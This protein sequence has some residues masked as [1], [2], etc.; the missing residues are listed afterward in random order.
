[1]RTK[2]RADRRSVPPGR[3][4]IVAVSTLLILAGAAVILYGVWKYPYADAQAAK[5]QRELADSLEWFTAPVT[6][7]DGSTDLLEGDEKR[8]PDSAPVMEA[9]EF[10][11]TF[12]TIMV[13]RWGADYVRP[14]SEGTD[15][16]AILDLLGVGHMVDT[17]MPGGWGN[18]AIAAH[19]TT[20]GKPFNQI[21][22]LREG[23]ALI[24]GTADAWYV[25]RVTSMSIVT[26]DETDVVAAV[27]GDVE[28]AP[29]DRYITLISCHPKD[30]ARQRYIVTGTLEY[31][32]DPADGVP[33]EALAS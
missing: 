12:A 32:G 30:S 17:A 31:W 8:D 23:D 27:P 22:E 24:V 28:A 2:K 10:G 4:W 33:A 18:F 6:A 13:P 25:Y 7:T 1:M 20:F 3:R 5:S 26:P 16:R 21:A 9:P 19:R 14:I 15:R 29:D 11:E